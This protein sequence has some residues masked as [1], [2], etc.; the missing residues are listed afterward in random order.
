MCERNHNPNQEIFCQ[1]PSDRYIAMLD[2]NFDDPR[3]VEGIYAIKKSGQLPVWFHSDQGSEY[4]SALICDWLISLGVSISMNPKG[5]PW[6]T[7][8]K[9]E[10]ILS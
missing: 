10:K 3:S 2:G 9:I 1:E 6:C 8:R 7:N 5:S 4:A